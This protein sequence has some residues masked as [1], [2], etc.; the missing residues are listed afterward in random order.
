MINYKVNNKPFRII[1]NKLFFDGNDFE[2]TP[3]FF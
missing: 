2:I 3:S 1:D